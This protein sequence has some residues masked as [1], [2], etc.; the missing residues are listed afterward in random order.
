VGIETA[1]IVGTVASV[2]AAGVA[3]EASREQGQAQAGAAKYNAAALSQQARVALQQSAAA[4]DQQRAANRDKLAR[5]RAGAA[6]GSTDISGSRS[7]LLSQDAGDAEYDAL[8]TRYKGRL[9]ASG[10]SAQAAEDKYQGAA[11]ARYGNQAFVGG[12]IGAG[13][14]GL[15]GYADSLKWQRGGGSMYGDR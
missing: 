1:L 7:D 8:L 5:M 12:M 15:S 13:A 6:E 10:L 14:Q 2:A 3:A 11:A 4:E 9:Q